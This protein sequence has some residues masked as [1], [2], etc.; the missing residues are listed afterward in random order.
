ML[1][2][3]SVPKSF[4]RK[5]RKVTAA[6]RTRAG[7]NALRLGV[8]ATMDHQAMLAEL[9]PVFVVDVGANRGQFALDVQAACPKASI[10]SFEP[11]P[12]AADTYEL[13]F[14]GAH[15]VELRNLALGSEAG[16]LDLF[17]SK[18]D[19]SSSLLPISAL[20]EST[21]PGTESIGSL[22]VGVSTLDVELQDIKFDR[23][24]LLKLDVQGYELQA[25]QGGT[26]SLG[27]FDW[28]YAE[29]SFK[30]FYSGQPLASDVIAFLA[31]H[32]FELDRVENITRISGSV[33]QADFLFSKRRTDESSR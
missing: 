17:L 5:A 8:V 28:I 16:E 6:V 10:L 31:Q 12:D 7:R 11:I 25:L 15:N 29:C 19:D 9:E 21:F 13:V 30:E 1:V 26:A 27:R 18:A 14:E 3:T 32:G 2:P 23:P 33:V 20:Q 22:R 24:A 4:F